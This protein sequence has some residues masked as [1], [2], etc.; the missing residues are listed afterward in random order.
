MQRTKKLIS[1]LV[2]LIVIFFVYLFL[3]NF[4]SCMIYIDKIIDK[5]YGYEIIIPE[6]ETQY[7]RKYAYKTLSETNNFEP[8]NIEDI[9]KIY[10]TVL[11]KGWKNFT[12][13]CRSDYKNCVTDVKKVADD[14]DYISL[15]NNYVS[16][17]NSYKKYNTLISGEK[18]I[19]LSIEKV[20]SQD[21]IDVLNNEI[22]TTI[23]KLNINKRNVTKEDLLK[24]QKYIIS[25]TTY[26]NDYTKSKNY[27]STTAYGALIKGKAIC[28][29]YTDAFALFLDYLSI[30]NFKITTEDHIWNVIYFKGNWSHVDITWDDDEKNKNN[31]TNF[32]MI[33]TNDLLKKDKK[34]HSFNTK[35]YLEIK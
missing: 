7:N 13:Y 18:E 10:Y 32:F 34:E 11:N 28:S 19:S 30:P 14:N 16:P 5:F 24:I 9:K 35:K 31:N 27:V 2:S 20:Y 33:T 29:G 12:F 17:Y 21:M 25:Q 1:T 23:K 4:D 6:N 15:L 8:K 3:M 22:E 26:D